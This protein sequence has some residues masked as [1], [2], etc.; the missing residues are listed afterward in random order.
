M[1]VKIA[2]KFDS[3]T[4][5]PY[6]PTLTFWFHILLSRYDDASSMSN[7]DKK[8]KDGHKKQLSEVILFL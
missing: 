8:D 4:S 6:E 3:T 2:E 1:T 5:P 7:Q